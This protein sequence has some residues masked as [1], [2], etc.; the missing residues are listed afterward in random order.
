[1][2][3]FRVLALVHRNQGLDL[4][5]P[6][7]VTKLNF[8]KLGFGR[9]SYGF[10]IVSVFLVLLPDEGHAGRRLTGYDSPYEETY[11]ETP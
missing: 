2:K 7:D 8:I 6:T 11:G 4:L 1:M 10:L 9:I 5:M 3:Y